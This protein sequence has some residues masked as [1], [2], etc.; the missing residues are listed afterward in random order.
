MTLNPTIDHRFSFPFSRC[1]MGERIGFSRHAK[2]D[3]SERVASL[4]NRR[5]AGLDYEELKILGRFCIVCHP[6]IFS[7]M[8][9]RTWAIIHDWKKWCFMKVGT[10]NSPRCIFIK[11]YI[12]HIS[13]PCELPTRWQLF[14]C[15]RNEVS[16]V[17]WKFYEVCLQ[18][19]CFVL[20]GDALHLPHVIHK[21]EH[22]HDSQ[23]Y[24]GQQEA[25]CCSLD[26]SLPII[27]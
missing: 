21:L 10:P 18:K 11:T 20:A 25:L 13:L 26:R 2:K 8:S 14:S 16:I 23:C 6:K 15:F 17:N 5:R 27:R 9:R 4:I 19:F 24:G 3:I 1:G 7:I 12:C 22:L